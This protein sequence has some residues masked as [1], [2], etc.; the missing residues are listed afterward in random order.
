MRTKETVQMRVLVPLPIPWVV[1]LH[2]GLMNHGG[3]QQKQ[4]EQREIIIKKND[5]KCQC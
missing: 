4:Q 3:A 1:T 2:S 5:S